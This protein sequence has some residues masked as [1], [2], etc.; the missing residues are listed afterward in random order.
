M[1]FWQTLI[2][3]RVML[4]KVLINLIF[5]YS[6]KFLDL[7][8]SWN[9]WCSSIFPSISIAENLY[10]LPVKVVFQLVGLFFHYIINVANTYIF[11]IY[12]NV[13][14]NNL[15]YCYVCVCMFISFISLNFYCFTR[16]KLLRQYKLTKQKS[17][18][19]QD[20][21]TNVRTKPQNTTDLFILINVTI[22]NLENGA[23]RS[24]ALLPPAPS[25]MI[26]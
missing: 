22:C 20:S 7:I 25:L 5:T 2:L 9:Y 26:I 15:R 1:F 4:K 8:H 19:N 23:S 18:K 12:P 10:W 11:S 13:T 6:N 3:M 14:L 17:E 24:T 21:S 16:V